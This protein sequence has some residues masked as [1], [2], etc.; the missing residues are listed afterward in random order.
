MYAGQ[1]TGFRPDCNDCVLII[2]VQIGYH[3]PS[4]KA[5]ERY[6][7][8][9]HACA[10]EMGVEAVNLQP[11]QDVHS[12]GDPLGQGLVDDL[13]ASPF[14]EQRGRHAGHFAGANP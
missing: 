8:W 14:R 9:C 6:L 2:H 12:I 13:A 1:R 4:P 5:W 10:A 7:Y 11:A 3:G